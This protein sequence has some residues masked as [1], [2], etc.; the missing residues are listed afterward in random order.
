MVF[1]ADKNNSPPPPT[2]TYLPKVRVPP[3]LKID[4]TKNYTRHKHIIDVKI[5]RS[6]MFIYVISEYFFIFQPEKKLLPKISVLAI[7]HSIFT[8]IYSYLNF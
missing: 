5:Y 3:K 2:C 4:I 8:T 6:S 7:L 1:L